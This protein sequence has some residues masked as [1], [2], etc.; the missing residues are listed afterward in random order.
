MKWWAGA[1]SRLNLLAKLFPLAIL[2]RKGHNR[3]AAA[4]ADLH[5]QIY[6]RLL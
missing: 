6:Y 3:A 2:S 1:E 5:M 4:A